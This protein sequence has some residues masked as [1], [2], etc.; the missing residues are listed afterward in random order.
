MAIEVA[1]PAVD[2]DDSLR[3]LFERL[4][5][6][7]IDSLEALYDLLS[8]RIYSLALWR[9]RSTSDAADVLQDVFV[10]LAS[11][12][13]Q[14]AT[15]RQPLHYVLRMAHHASIDVIR[16]RSREVEIDASTPLMQ[17]HRMNMNSIHL[18]AAVAELPADQREAI[19]LR[20]VSGFSLR[21]IAG[22]TGVSLF[23]AA[24]RCRLALRKLRK[25]LGDSYE[26]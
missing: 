8:S 19:Y 26:T 12:G 21:E 9:T 15:V 23:T 24:S 11:M 13:K 18:S 10:K 7:D 20:Y 4:S 6:G 5:R 16:K 17:Q 3:D 2:Q 22:I 1:R 25:R 14:L